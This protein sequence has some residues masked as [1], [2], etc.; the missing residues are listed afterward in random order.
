VSG[1]FTSR[2]VL[3]FVGFT[4]LRQQYNDRRE[5]TGLDLP[6]ENEPEF[7]AYMLIFDLTNK[8]VSIPISELPSR[9]LDHPLVKIAWS[10]RQAAQRNFDSQ[11]EGSKLNAELG[12]NFINRYIR[13]LRDGNLPFLFACL[14]EVRLREMRRSILRAMCRSYPRLKT[15][16][17]RFNEE[18][19]V[20]ERKMV[21]V[22][23]LVDVLGCDEQEEDEGAWDDV[24]LGDRKRDTEVVEIAKRFDLEVYEDVTGPVGVMIN[25]ASPFNGQSAGRTE[26]F[27]RTDNSQ[28]IGML[29]TLSGGNRSRRDEA[30]RLTPISS[31]GRP[32]Y[33]LMVR[34][35]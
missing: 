16:P 26:A 5:E 1:P 8:S 35:R 14:V 19:E 23:T 18:G 25:L 12:M 31:M 3:S 33:I 13:V 4:S 17:V 32:A 15:D 10:L 21:L 34:L 2:T 22:G 29:H 11:K 27:V 30:V 20:V 9:I 6:C 28:T 24:G 7:R